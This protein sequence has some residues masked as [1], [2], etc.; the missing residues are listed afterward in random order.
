[1]SGWSE[2]FLAVLALGSLMTSIGLLVFVVAAWRIARR[3]ELLAQRIEREIAPAIGHMNAMTRDAAR[4]A[5]LARAQVERFD[6][7]FGDL[8]DTVQQPVGVVQNLVTGPLRT[9]GAASAAIRAF[10]AALS[11]MRENSAGGSRART[12]DE[13]ALFI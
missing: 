1:M 13:D 4:G 2:A 5:S 8:A 7:V 3:V 9:G 11:V 10:W 12:E 6:R